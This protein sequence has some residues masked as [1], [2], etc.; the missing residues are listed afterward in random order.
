MGAPSERLLPIPWFLCRA[1]AWRGMTLFLFYCKRVGKEWPAPNG[2]QLQGLNLWC[3]TSL[4]QAPLLSLLPPPGSDMLQFTLSF[5]LKIDAAISRSG[6]RHSVH[7]MYPRL[8]RGEGLWFWNKCEGKIYKWQMKSWN[9]TP[10]RFWQSFSDHLHPKLEGFGSGFPVAHLQKS[11]ITSSS[12]GEPGQNRER[13]NEFNLKCFMEMFWVWQVCG[14][15]LPCFPGQL[16]GP[17]ASGHSFG[18]PL[19]PIAAVEDLILGLMMDWC[20]KSRPCN[21]LQYSEL[22]LIFCS[23]LFSPSFP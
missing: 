22:N 7:E 4:L 19:K 10:D 8:Q 23:F 3:V 13:G 16:L 20:S 21:L 12:R 15:S 14:G 11:G 17:W 6:S 5:N 2:K 18:I 1:V 9:P